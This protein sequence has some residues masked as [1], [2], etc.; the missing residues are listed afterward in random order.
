MIPS[1]AIWRRRLPLLAV[2]A[3][4]SVGNFVFFLSYRSTFHDRRQALEARRDELKRAV[5]AREVEATKLAGQRERL[6][7][8]SAA[9]EEFYGRRVGPQRETLAS[10]VA[11]VHAVLRETGVS[12][13]Q[14]SY[15]T[16]P[17]PK[18]PLTQMRIQ[19][20]V[21]C[22]YGRFKRLLRA[23]ETDK[24][25]IAVRSIAVNRDAEQPGSVQVQLELATY[26]ADREAL[27]ERPAK[28]AA[29]ARRTS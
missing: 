5:E 27:P 8:V 3:L 7:G 13:S 15:T 10:I 24:R 14:I 12:T 17:M 20:P 28:A 11:E 2:A 18:L 25:W 19:F 26:F 22:D 23:F 1:T 16:T 6:D 4:F 9:I 21:R 29:P